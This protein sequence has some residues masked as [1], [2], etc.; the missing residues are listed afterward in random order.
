MIKLIMTTQKSHST[1]DYKGYA[2]QLEKTLDL[3]L[4]KK[5]P[6]IPEGGKEFIVKFVPWIT[7]MFVIQ[8]IPAVLALLGIGTIVA[9]VTFLGGLSGGVAYILNLVFLLASLVLEAMAIPGLFKRQ[10]KGW[11]RIYYSILVGA[12]YSLFTMNLYGLVVGMLI[13]LYILFQ[14]KSYYK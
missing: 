9:P 11:D 2:S 7:I 14:V 10:R 1:T 5:A 13:S 12:L 4:V 3:Y 8:T 6:A